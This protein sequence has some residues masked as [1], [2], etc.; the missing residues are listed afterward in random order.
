MTNHF[1]FSKASS[2]DEIR[3]NAGQSL[4][5][6]I[7][8]DLNKISTLEATHKLSDSVFRAHVTWGKVWDYIKALSA[9]FDNSDFNFKFQE[10]DYLKKEKKT[11]WAL[12]V[13]S[14]SNMVCRTVFQIQINMYNPTKDIAISKN[15]QISFENAHV[16]CITRISGF[17]FETS[18]A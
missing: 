5:E 11:R 2:L 15:K 1:S 18:K 8:I 7:G 9:L 10:F 3:E 14:T 17:D 12:S 4:K 16:E 13:I 6:A